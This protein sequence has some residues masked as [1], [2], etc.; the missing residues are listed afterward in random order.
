[1]IERDGRPERY[2]LSPE[3]N[4]AIFTERLLPAVFGRTRGVE[5]PS[6]NFFGAQ[7]GAGKSVL[8]R[9]LITTLRRQTGKESVAAIIGDEFRPYHPLYNDFLEQNDELAAFYTDRDSATW[10]EKSIAY[11]L[12]VRPHVVLEGTLRNP[13]ITLETAADYH[14][15]GFST[16]LHL[17]A[18]HEF[19]SRTRIFGRYLDQIQRNGHGRYTLPEAHDRAYRVLPGSLRT[20]ATAGIMDRITLYNLNGTPIATATGDEPEASTV[21]FSALEAE[22]DPSRLDATNLDDILAQYQE[23][24]LPYHR[25]N[26]VRDIEALRTEIVDTLNT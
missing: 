24:L 7:P 1:M 21:L 22:R 12:E 26:V 14:R 15:H 11:T 13:A 25:E 5:E 10:V 8:Q 3:E 20:I 17:V 19:I 18:V 6:A 23:Q 2:L 4:E 9:E 16:E